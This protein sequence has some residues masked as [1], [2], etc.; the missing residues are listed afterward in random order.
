MI[1]TLVP[2]A[3]LSSYP[4]TEVRI[5]SIIIPPPA[6]IKPHINPMMIPQIT[7]CM[8][9]FLADTPCIASLVVITGLT[10]NLIPNRKVIK[11]EKLPMVADGTRLDI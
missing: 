4:R 3:V 5:R 9:R 8:A 11:T 6:P 7:D 2:T 1:K 10:M